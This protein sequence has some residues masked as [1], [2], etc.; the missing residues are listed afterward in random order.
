MK[1]DMGPSSPRKTHLSHLTG[2]SVRCQHPIGV[3]SVLFVL[4][5]FYRKWKFPDTHSFRNNVYIAQVTL[6]DADVNIA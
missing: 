6:K 5:C 4:D 3:N 2:N 1:G